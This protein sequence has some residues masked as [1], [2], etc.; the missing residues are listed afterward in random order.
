MKAVRQVVEISYKDESFIGYLNFDEDEKYLEFL[1][2]TVE[3]QIELL[4]FYSPK[5][6]N[7]TLHNGKVISCFNCKIIRVKNDNLVRYGIDIYVEN[8]IKRYEELQFNNITAIFP[9]VDFW[10]VGSGF[11]YKS[12]F[13]YKGQKLDLIISEGET[14]QR[15]LNTV[16]SET[17]L[18]VQLKSESLMNLELVNEIYFK[19]SAILS[20]LIDEFVSYTHYNV[21]H[22]GQY[23]YK[24][25]QRNQNRINEVKMNKMNYRIDKELSDTDFYNIFVVPLTL[26][27]FDV[28]FNYIGVLRTKPLLEERYLT[29][30]RCLEMI[31]RENVNTDIY[32]NAERRAKSKIYRELIEGMDLDG[33]YKENLIEAF[34]FSNRKGFKVLLLQ[35]IQNSSFKE[36]LEMLAE[37][38]DVEKLVSNIV[39]IRNHLTHGSPFE[40]IDKSSLSFYTELIKR[41]VTYFILQKHM[42]DIP[43][44]IDYLNRNSSELPD[45]FIK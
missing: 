11:S 45:P 17:F 21:N 41:M 43:L 39:N 9:K 37:K 5:T 19:M 29:Y 30:A 25:Y 7:C 12:N 35:L 42:V 10:F 32:G 38:V 4:Q 36:Q 14:K 6:F 8:D 40:K 16:I 18:R 3:N 44:N 20:F 1:V 13:D 31:S 15:G 28:W 2:D 34:K 22:E 24:I 26:K 23:L 27:N 33:D